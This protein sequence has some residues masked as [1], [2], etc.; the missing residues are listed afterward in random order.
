M[1]ASCARRARRGT[2]TRGIA[3]RSTSAAMPRR[4]T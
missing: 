1:D 3:K 4:Q 2:A